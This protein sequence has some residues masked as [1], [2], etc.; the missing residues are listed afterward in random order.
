LVAHAE[1]LTF[2]NKLPDV[3]FGEIILRFAEVDLPGGARI[4]GL[5]FM[6]LKIN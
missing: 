4:C 2:K 5:V 1:G 3:S 6:T